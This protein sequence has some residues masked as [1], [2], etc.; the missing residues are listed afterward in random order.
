V[1]GVAHLPAAHRPVADLRQKTR[2]SDN[3]LDS[4]TRFG[5]ARS[6][7][8]RPVRPMRDWKADVN[9]I[10]RILRDEWNPIG[11]DVPDDEYD[12]YIPAVYQLLRGG[13][14]AEEISRRLWT[15]ETTD[16]RLADVAGITERNDRVV[17][18]LLALMDSG[19][20]E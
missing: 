8:E 19:P 12:S 11:F 4:S 2:G 1:D 5:G 15:F 16:M 10:R 7:Q 3:P 17:G 20:A 14:S 13:A 6:V 9:A 18:L